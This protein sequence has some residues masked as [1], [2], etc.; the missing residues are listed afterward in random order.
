MKKT[1]YRL[2]DSLI[3]NFIKKG[4]EVVVK[5]GY[6]IGFIILRLG[7][8]VPPSSYYKIK[9]VNKLNKLFL[10]IKNIEGDPVK[11]TFFLGNLL[12]PVGVSGSV[13]GLRY[14]IFLVL[15][16]AGAFEGSNAEYIRGIFASAPALT[17]YH[18]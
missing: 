14:I 4:K 1:L 16:N 12:T 5:P 2:N 15:C 13:Q 17:K 7:V 11:R 9:F 8:R 3:H 6:H 18:D 10:K